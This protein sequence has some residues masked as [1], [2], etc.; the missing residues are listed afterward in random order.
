[1]A[2][3]SKEAV[4]SSA[5]EKQGYRLDKVGDRYRLVNPETGTVVAD[6]W[7]TGNGLTLDQLAQVLT[8]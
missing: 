7:T 5:V 4:L 6:D 1:M 2:T 8:P 3:R